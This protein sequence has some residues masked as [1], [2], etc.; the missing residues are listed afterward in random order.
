MV[1]I[2]LP[3]KIDSLSVN[4]DYQVTYDKVTIEY[5]RP[6]F[7]I[8]GFKVAKVF[9]EAKIGY[10]KRATPFYLLFSQMMNLMGFEDHRTQ[11]PVKEIKSFVTKIEPNSYTRPLIKTIVK[12]NLGYFDP[13]TLIK[14]DPEEITNPILLNSL[15]LYYPLYII[16]DLKEDCNN[17]PTGGLHV[18]SKYKRK[19]YPIERIPI[20]YYQNKKL[21]WNG[22]NPTSAWEV[23]SLD[24]KLPNLFIG[25]SLIW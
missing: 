6:Y 24:F 25:E 18:Y 15:T 20:V 10:I 14:C 23:E 3:E 21:I 5:H 12:T 11:I 9:P 7:T 17:G 8:Y 19:D 4:C 2:V 13:D 1:K 22:E 16:M